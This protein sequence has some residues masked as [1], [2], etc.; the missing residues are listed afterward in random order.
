MGGLSPMRDD[1]GVVITV[2]NL[3]AAAQLTSDAREQLGALGRVAQA[4]PDFPVQ[5]VVHSTGSKAKSAEARD[6]ER[7]RGDSVAKALSEAGASSERISV[8]AA[9]SAHPVLDAS[10]SRNPSRSERIEIIFVDPGG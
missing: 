8:E 4:H 1:R 5:V 3:F 7:K 9:G 10:V 2:R 6:D